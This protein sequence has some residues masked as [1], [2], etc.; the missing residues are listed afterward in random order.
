MIDM[1]FDFMQQIRE[2][3]DSLI[4][5]TIGYGFALHDEIHIT[6]LATLSIYVGRFVRHLLRIYH[7]LPVC[8]V[9]KGALQNHFAEIRE[10]L[11]IILCKL[12][13]LFFQY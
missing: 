8:V 13:P 12:K 5:A 1:I 7:P 6:V 11:I 9:L 10:Q 4:Y 3:N 2:S